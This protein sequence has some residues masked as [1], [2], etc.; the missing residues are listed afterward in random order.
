MGD[1]KKVMAGLSNIIRASQDM[2]YEQCPFCGSFEID[3]SYVDGRKAMPSECLNCGAC[4][5]HPYRDTE[6]SLKGYDVLD[7]WKIEKGE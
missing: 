2:E 1:F 5:I 7:G 3:G 6:E 4:E